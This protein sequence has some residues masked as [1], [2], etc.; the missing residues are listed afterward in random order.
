M[1]RFTA[2]KT[3]KV[4]MVEDSPSDVRLMR[5]ALRD[6]TLAV[7]IAVAKDGVEAVDYLQGCKTQP[8][9]WPDLVVL[10]LNLPKMSGREVLAIVKSDP[11]LKKIPVLIMTSSHDERDIFA[12]YNLNAN[13]YIRKPYDLNE[14]ERVVKAI[15][16]FWFLTVTLPDSYQFPLSSPTTGLNVQSIH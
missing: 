8:V 9:Q 14:Y 11:V 16:A 2:T 5:E 7:Q 12:A 10:D 1:E 13:C 6:S 4:L 15:E 3:V